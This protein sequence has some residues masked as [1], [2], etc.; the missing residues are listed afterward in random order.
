MKSPFSKPL[1]L[2][3]SRTTN[4]PN[5][6][7][8]DPRNSEKPAPQT[9]PFCK[10][11]SEIDSGFARLCSA[12]IEHAGE[13]NTDDHFRTALSAAMEDLPWHRRKCTICKK[14]TRYY[15]VFPMCKSSTW[16]GVDSLFLPNAFRL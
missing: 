14:G 8:D 7:E 11:G 3:A 16:T 13:S 12:V 15:C 9:L 5:S 10:L 6:G 4:A 1:N 2:A